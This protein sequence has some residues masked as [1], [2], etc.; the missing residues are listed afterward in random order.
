MTSPTFSVIIPAYNRK[1]LVRRAVQSVLAQH[2]CDFEVLVVDDAS[3]DG[4]WEML[5]SLGD[6]R[7]RILRHPINKGGS[8]ARNTGLAAARGS[9]IAFLDSDDYW[10]PQKLLE[11]RAFI[12]GIHSRQW[13]MYHPYY[14][15]TSRGRSVS[16]T[17]CLPRDTT[18]AEFLFVRRGG[19]QTSSVLAPRAL[20]AAV[21]FDEQLRRLQDWDFYVRAERMGA[22][23]WMLPQVLSVHNAYDDPSRISSDVDPSFLRRWI[24]DR[25]AEVG[26]RAY[27]AFLANKLAPEAAQDGH[28]LEAAGLLL[29]GLVQGVVQPRLAAID[30]A[31]IGLPGAVFDSV[32]N[33]WPRI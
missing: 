14:V 8:A 6:P 2:E 3:T 33:Y 30:L 24:E 15:D 28:R 23:F 25:R 16:T 20:A 11:C 17:E 4:S 29:R 21:G 19:V 12:D 18:L 13:V 5:S 7:V 9:F 10:L 32:R 31:R 1:T 26:E 22:S 27:V